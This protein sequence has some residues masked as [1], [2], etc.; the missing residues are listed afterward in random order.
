[1]NRNLM[2]EAQPLLSCV[3]WKIEVTEVGRG[4]EGHWD[5]IVLWEVSRPTVLG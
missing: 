4:E 1:M 3:E 2:T 5:P